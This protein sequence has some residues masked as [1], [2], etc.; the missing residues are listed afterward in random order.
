MLRG[1][2]LNYGVME[3][4]KNTAII[5]D[6]GQGSGQVFFLGMLGLLFKL[7]SQPLSVILAWVQGRYFGPWSFEKSQPLSVLLA[8]VKGRYI[9]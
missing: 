6:I 3:Y 1:G 5:C 8:Q 9:S 7:K 4:E 2:I